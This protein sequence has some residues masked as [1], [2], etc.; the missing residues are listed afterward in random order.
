MS[1]PLL[2]HIDVPPAELMRF[3][4]AGFQPI[5]AKRS[6]PDSPLYGDLCGAEVADVRAV[7]TIG[8][9][10]LSAEQM[11]QLPGLRIICCLGA[12]YER[13]DVAAAAARGIAVTHGPGTNDQSVAD[14]A[15]ALLLALVRDIAVLDRL[16]RQGQ[17]Q[18][19]RQVRPQP[20]GKR[21]G[22][23]GLGHIGSNIARR[24]AYGFGMQVAYYSRR[25]QADVP[26]QYMDSAL[27]LARWADFL[28]I[29]TPG[30]A[31]TYH[32]VDDVL[33]AALG[34][35]GYLVNIARGSVV[36]NQALI[37]ALQ[38]HHIAGAALDVVE[39]EP[40]LPQELCQLDNVLITPHMAGRSPEA[41]AAVYQRVLANLACQFSGRELVSPVPAADPLLASREP[42]RE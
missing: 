13:V 15:M 16:V 23:L 9:L 12:G 4:H 14:H 41:M 22:I 19:L 35:A 5:Q 42:N 2:L 33:L 8:S 34:P 25:Q 28:V 21:L 40:V 20:S 37:R 6:Q 24:G 17:W 1:I 29:A 36:D 39:G 18:Q 31:G 27:D 3:E 38:H 11:D 26:W 7:L 10:G 32:L 30:G